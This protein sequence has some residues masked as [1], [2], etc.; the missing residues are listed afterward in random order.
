MNIG[1]PTVP[2]LAYQRLEPRT[3]KHRKYVQHFIVR[4]SASGGYVA[5]ALYEALG[6]PLE[7]QSSLE[8]LCPGIWAWEGLA[9]KIWD[10]SS[11]RWS[12]D[13]FREST[14]SNFRTVPPKHTS[15][16]GLETESVS[17]HGLDPRCVPNLSLRE[18]LECMASG[19]LEPKRITDSDIPWWPL[20]PHFKTPAGLTNT[21]ILCC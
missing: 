7:K 14:H 12:C 20:P 5:S 11:M 17:V 6:R 21:A 1:V 9:P 13:F 15:V 10:L 18:V 4:T 3:G 2:W 16:W 19:Q 8:A